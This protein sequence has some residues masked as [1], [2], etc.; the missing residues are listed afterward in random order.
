MRMFRRQP[1]AGS[2]RRNPA[3]G[4]A[5]GEVHLPNTDR[6]QRYSVFWTGKKLNCK[7]MDAAREAGRPGPLIFIDGSWADLH[8]GEYRNAGRGELAVSRMAADGQPW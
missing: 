3:D 2:L 5:Y 1:P 4:R 7:A 6:G 8:T